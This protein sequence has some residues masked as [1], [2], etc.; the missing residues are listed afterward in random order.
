MNV[1]T[2][3]GKRNVGVRDLRDHLSRYLDEVRDGG[4]LVVTEHGRP[5]ARILPAAVVP[6]RL[7]EL[8]AA[9]SARSPQSKRRKLPAAVR[10]VGSLS[11]LV[12][13]QRR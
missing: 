4:E 8:I 12:A 7:T 11:D 1:A 2:S 3:A 5:I 6:D 9:G 10:G 13:A